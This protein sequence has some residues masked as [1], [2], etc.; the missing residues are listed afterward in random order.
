MSHI[1]AVEARSWA[2]HI[3]LKGVF[4]MLKSNKD[5]NEI[6]MNYCIEE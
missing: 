4:D 5:E 6:P 1:P 2:Y 3:Y